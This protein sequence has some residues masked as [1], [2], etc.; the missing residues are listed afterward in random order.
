MKLRRAHARSRTPGL[1][2]FG[3]HCSRAN[4]VD[5]PDRSNNESVLDRSG[6][7]L[8]LDKSSSG[9]SRFRRRRKNKNAAGSKSSSALLGA[10][11]SVF[12]DATRNDQDSVIEQMVDALSPRVAKA[13]EAQAAQ[14]NRELR[15]MLAAIDDGGGGDSTRTSSPRRTSKCAPTSRASRSVRCAPAPTRSPPRRRRADARVVT[16]CSTPAP[17]RSTHSHQT[18]CSTARTRMTRHARLEEF[19]AIASLSAR[20]SMLST[21]N[22][23]TS[24]ARQRWSK[25][26]FFGE[27]AERAARR[28]RGRRPCGRRDARSRCACTTR[29][30]R[31][32]ARDRVLRAL[33]RDG[34]PRLRAWPGGTRPAR[35]PHR[36]STIMRIAVT[37]SPATCAS[38]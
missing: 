28:P 9:N 23:A 7:S 18:N 33:P 31:P 34:R 19:K 17:R 11:E 29:A 13:K 14:K 15:A 25:E 3:P 8:D 27:A 2:R 6:T 32:R 22:T 21:A 35:L 4:G 5:L 24:S 30:S 1:R 10:F 37:A 16:A 12:E 20:A 38:A 26:T 36:P